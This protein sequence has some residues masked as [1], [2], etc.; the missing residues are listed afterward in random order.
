MG[1]IKQFW[2]ESDCII[3]WSMQSRM[4]TDIVLNSLLMAVWRCNPQKQVLIHSDQGSHY[5]SHEWQLFLKSQGLEG[6]MS[7]SGNCHGNAVA[8][9][10]SSS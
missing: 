6:S 7:R 1:Q 10:F 3:G 8:E 2:L 4:T 9:S 5:I